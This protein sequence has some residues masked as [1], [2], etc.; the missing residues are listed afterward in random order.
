MWGFNL[1]HQDYKHVNI[2]EGKNPLDYSTTE[3]RGE[4]YNLMIEAGTVKVLNTLTLSKVYGVS[5]KTISNDRKHLQEYLMDSFDKGSVLPDVITAKK[6]ALKAAME[7][8]DYRIVDKITDSILGMCFDL[9][10]IAKASEKLEVES[11][12]IGIGD[13]V[14][15][16]KER[17]REL[18]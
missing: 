17:K 8:R 6:W 7:A 9:G 15:A 4:E 13:L 1:I 11:N 3:R 2:A 5:P 16:F 14:E 10:I 12:I 18:E